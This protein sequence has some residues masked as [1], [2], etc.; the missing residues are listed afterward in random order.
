MGEVV[1]LRTRRKAQARAARSAQAAQN[2]ARFGRA[3]AERRRAK[4]ET[5]KAASE[6][7]GRRLEG[8][9]DS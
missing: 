9:D 2:R 1:N 3:L 8:G 6:L 7:D 5:L 4:A